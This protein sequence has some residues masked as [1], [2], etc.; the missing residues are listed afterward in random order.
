MMQ[1]RWVLAAAGVLLAVACGP[2]Q[3]AAPAEQA[4]AGD[5]PR[6]G[7]TLNE[8]IERDP[9]DWDITYQGKSTPN[10]DGLGL[11]FNGLLRF[12]SGPGVEFVEN[13]LE[14]DLAER[15]EVAPDGRSFTFHLPKGV[16]FAN[17]PP[18][19]GRELTSADIKWT[20]EYRTRTGELKDKNLPRGQVDFMFEGLERVDT[21]DPYTAIARFKD[22]FV[23]FVNYAASRW[24]PIMAREVYQ[25]DGHLKDLP[26][27]TG[28]YI[29]DTAST[30]KGTRWVW[31]KNPDYFERDKPYIDEIRWLVIADDAAQFA[32]FQVKQLDRLESLAHAAFQ[33]VQKANPEIES[34]QYFAT[35]AQQLLLSQ[36]RG[37]P[38]TDLRVRRAISMALDRD[39]LNRSVA[40]GQGLWAIPAATAG[41]YSQEETRKLVRQDLNEAK[42]LLAEAGFPSG[43]ELE[44]PIPRTE[45]Q[46][47]VSMFQL[48]QAQLK[49]IG[50]NA[51]LK[52][53]D[54]PDQR[55][56]RRTG[57]FDFDA[58]IGGTGQL[59]SDLDSL[60]YGKYHSTVT[61]NYVQAKDPELDKLLEASR[62]EIDPAKRQ[63]VLKQ[64]SMRILEMVWNVDTIYVPRFDAWH[65]HLKNYGNHYTDRP[66]YRHAWIEK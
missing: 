15:W 38:L 61:G 36:A 53:M 40:G 66:T 45:S 25:Q 33:E 3:Q 9:Y 65:P 64:I 24:N 41:T 1:R 12:K 10:T 19:N 34:Q 62:K 22:P 55:K 26:I 51:V 5:Q 7:G 6:S 18:V 35:N 46:A 23:P 42:R 32:A 14:P 56:K 49:R 50:I 11:A 4:A 20:L 63:D 54:L 39:E 17:L 13:Q 16:K 52:P 28:P 59:N 58:S 47:N 44:W 2:A 60:I 37:G 57:D 29:L 21:P 43:L 8:T 31:K 27:G 30:Q 48:V